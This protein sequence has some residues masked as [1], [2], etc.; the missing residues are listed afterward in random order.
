MGGRRR[1]Y[2]PA[3]SGDVFANPY[4]NSYTYFDSSYYFD[5]YRNS[6]TSFNSNSYSDGNCNRDANADTY[7]YRQPDG[8]TAAD[9]HCQTPRNCEAAPNGCTAAGMSDC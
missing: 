1:R 3:W 2:L 6:Y 8:Y 4:C 5:A 9:A 7:V